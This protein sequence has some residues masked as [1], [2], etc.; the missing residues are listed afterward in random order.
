VSTPDAEA[1]ADTRPE[2]G[3]RVGTGG[4]VAALERLAHHH[5][6]RVGR[7][8]MGTVLLYLWAPIFV[9]VLMSFAERG[10]LSF[11]PQSLTLRWYG[12]FL[13]NET[14][15]RAILT[16][17]RVSLPATVVSV[18]LATLIAYA[19]VRFGFPGRR[20]L[21]LLATLPIVVPLVV[22]GVA[23]V[24]FFGVLEVRTGYG[25]VLVAHVV[26]T[27]PFS[28]LI[29]VSTLLRFDRRLE[30]ASMDLG[31]DELRTF[32]KVTLPSIA[33]GVVAAGL[34]AFTVSFNEFVYTY[35]VKDTATTTLPVYI[36][37]RVR[38]G[39]TPEV[40]VISVVFVLVAGGLLLVAV[41][42]TEVERITGR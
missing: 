42:L 36:W 18:T 35:F 13:A 31:A 25:T 37:D 6:A 20:Y 40:N 28:T 26:R 16:S 24:L 38:Y 8:A 41:R 32:R 34:L 14:A 9:L 39:V 19:V 11:P 7:V 33:P 27:I 21:Q 29:V 4:P 3:A 1:E 2:T 10:V 12:V 15:H 5:G 30:E 22:V 17:L 23:M